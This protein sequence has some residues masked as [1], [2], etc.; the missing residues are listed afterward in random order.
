VIEASQTSQL[1]DSIDAEIQAEYDKLQRSIELRETRIN[2]L[3]WIVLGADA[4][5]WSIWVITYLAHWSMDIDDLVEHDIVDYHYGRSYFDLFIVLSV[6]A[7]AVL[8]GVASTFSDEHR[9]RVLTSIAYWCTFLSFILTF[10]KVLLIE[11]YSTPSYVVVSIFAIIFETIMLGLQRAFAPLPAKNEWDASESEEQQQFLKRKKQHEEALARAAEIAATLSG[12]ELE[13]HQRKEAAR[14]ES[15]EYIEKQAQRARMAAQANQSMRLRELS[16]LMKPYFW[17]AGTKEKGI[18]LLAWGTLIASKTCSILAPL[19]VG[20]AANTIVEENRVPW[21]YISLF[22]GLTFLA[23]GLKQ[24]QSAIY[25][26]VKQ[27]SFLILSRYSFEHV[28][29][30]SIRYE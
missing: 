15:Y 30:L 10:C 29:N 28:L 24:L 6:R 2:R 7:V 17:P 16:I 11:S 13:E 25:L 27:Q 21:L 23:Q 22:A 12:A 26:E 14:I 1:L 18:V 5:F 20:Y 3:W 9:N 19:Y 4:L 8:L